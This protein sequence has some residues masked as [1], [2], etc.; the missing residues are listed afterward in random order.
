[1][2]RGSSCWPVS[3]K[4]KSLGGGWLKIQCKQQ[5]QPFAVAPELSAPGQARHHHGRPTRTSSNACTGIY[6]KGRIGDS[7]NAV[8]AAAAYLLLRWLA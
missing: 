6:L 8:L 1:M 5:A 4:Y 2:K 7:I 3:V